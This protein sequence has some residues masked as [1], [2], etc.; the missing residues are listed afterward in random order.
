MQLKES[1]TKLE[2][3]LVEKGPDNIEVPAEESEL[4]PP[5]SEVVMAEVEVGSV[6]TS[7]KTLNQDK[8]C[9]IKNNDSS[10]TINNSLKKVSN[11]EN[12]QLN[13]SLNNK[14]VD[15]AH[16]ETT[17]VPEAPVADTSRTPSEHLEKIDEK[18]EDLEIGTIEIK[19]I[20][21]TPYC[22]PDAEDDQLLNEVLR[23]NIISCVEKVALIEERKIKVD[24]SN[25][26]DQVSVC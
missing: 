23:Q 26:E 9:N 4:P 14:T 8:S 16:P 17:T 3:M 18:N 21:S 7:E 2:S 5:N 10:M 25:N 19:E 13:K 20:E 1:E 22:E 24:Y 11:I 15:V 12:E 6:E